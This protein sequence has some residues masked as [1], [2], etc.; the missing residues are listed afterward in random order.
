MSLG[1]RASRRRS[2][3]LGEL[4]GTGVYPPEWSRDREVTRPAWR[5]YD[6][7]GDDETVAATF[8][9]GDRA[10]RRDAGRP[11]RYRDHHRHRLATNAANLIEASAAKTTSSTGRA[12]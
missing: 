10:R 5:R 9:Y 7:F 8:S 6:I 12:D 11:D 3:A 4:T 1:T 2:R